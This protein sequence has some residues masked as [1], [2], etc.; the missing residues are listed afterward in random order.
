MNFSVRECK[1]T[2]TSKMMRDNRMVLVYNIKKVRDWDDYSVPT[3]DQEAAA[4]E[5][6]L[7]SDLVY[8]GILSKRKLY[9]KFFKEDPAI[10]CA[11]KERL[12]CT[13]EILSKTRSNIRLQSVFFNPN[14]YMNQENG[15]TSNATDIVSLGIKNVLCRLPSRDAGHIINILHLATETSNTSLERKTDDDVKLDREAMKHAG[16]EEHARLKEYGIETHMTDDGKSDAEGIIHHT[17]KYRNS[18][19]EKHIENKDSGNITLDKMEKEEKSKDECQKRQQEK[20]RVYEDQSDNFCSKETHTTAF[21]KEN[22]DS[23]DYLH[24]NRYPYPSSLS[25]SPSPL[26]MSVLYPT[27][28]SFLRAKRS[29][30]I[31]CRSGIALQNTEFK[32]T[33]VTGDD[34]CAQSN[35]N[36]RKKKYLENAG[37]NASCW[38]GTIP[39]QNVEAQN[40]R[41]FDDAR[42]VYY[43][44]RT[45]PAME[46]KDTDCNIMMAGVGPFQDS[47]DFENSIFREYKS[48]NGFVKKK[49]SSTDNFG[50]IG[51]L[52]PPPTTAKDVI[53]TEKK[54]YCIN[55]GKYGHLFKK[56][57]FPI[58]SFGLIGYH[59]DKVNQEVSFIM[60]QSKNTFHFLD[61]IRGKY[62]LNDSSAIRRL[63][64]NMTESELSVL[65]SKNFDAIWKDT[66]HDIYVLN[67][68]QENQKKISKT[69]YD[70]LLQGYEIEGIRYSLDY[71]LALN[72][73]SKVEI[74]WSFPKGRRNYKESDLMCAIRE[75]EEE[76]G[77]K[78]KF[79]EIKE[80][81][82]IY[83]ETY[84]GDNNIEYQH[85]YFLAEFHQKISLEISDTNSHQVI[86]VGMLKWLNQE[87]AIV[88]IHPMYQ[89]RIQIVK[90][91]V[92]EILDSK[93]RVCVRKYG[94][95]GQK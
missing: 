16:L 2:T 50:G 60:I 65:A 6:I 24:E 25:M 38:L 72:H 47:G 87:E 79:F 11:C 27:A 63:F 81:K 34:G 77:L 37:Q 36:M 52:P 67:E 85:R 40:H 49:K 84:T 94:P 29:P 48:K 13:E 22:G 39:C 53:E 88:N 10:Y 89:Q 43:S 68:M 45:G 71:F 83:C 76:T 8:S 7:S 58:L 42:G 82:K 74:S 62:D 64:E 95:R 78:R 33:D 70:Y 26:S 80:P 35:Y 54:S 93:K 66:Y 28:E 46:K 56:C 15:R 90:T 1:G 32:V 91:F 18:S 5:K 55:C 3:V 92:Q 14:I 23:F 86:E 9:S 20:S 31:S 4:D 21:K 19:V 69:K 61:F 12:L 75:F 59:Y 51:T 41:N 73:T 57:N 44:P 30:P 17:E